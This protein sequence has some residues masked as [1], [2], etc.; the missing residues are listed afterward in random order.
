MDTDLPNVLIVGAGNLGR[1]IGKLLVEKK[2]Q[3]AF[4]DVDPTKVPGGVLLEK[5]VPS[6]DY[7]L[8]C[9][10]SWAVREALRNIA[11]LLKKDAVVACF[12]KGIDRDTLKTM[13][14]LLPELLPNGQASAVVG[15]PMLASEIMAGEKAVGV[16]ASHDPKTIDGLRSLFSSPVF[17]VETSTDM[18]SVALEGVL[19]NIYAVALGIADGLVLGGNEKGWLASRAEEEMSAIAVA[20]HADPRAVSGTAGM[21]D[22]IATGYSSYS[23][24]RAAGETLG[25]GDIPTIQ[26]EGLVSLP[27]LLDRLG[28]DANHFPLL[29]LIADI[30]LLGKPPGPALEAFF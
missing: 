25:K 8:L 1:A 24:N 23:E 4:W 9:V 20:L 19:K 16:F 21:A 14:E 18:L 11:P 30:G 27:F 22:L 15:G 12:S 13:G 6:A 26:G 17:K 5:A 3:A 7:V 28:P 10:P 29:N 2:I